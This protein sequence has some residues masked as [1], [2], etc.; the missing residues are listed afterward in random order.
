[1]IL[2]LGDVVQGE[3]QE[4]AN[5]KAETEARSARSMSERKDPYDA[6][7]EYVQENNLRDKGYQ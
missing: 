7:E 3:Q 2:V 6:A 1:M 5:E 4:R